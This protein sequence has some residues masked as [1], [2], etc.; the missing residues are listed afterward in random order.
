MICIVKSIFSN[1]AR[2]GR[3]S[4]VPPRT[5][6]TENNLTYNITE[7]KEALLDQLID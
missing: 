5:T 7:Q 3:R 6:M 4:F 1:T 2:S